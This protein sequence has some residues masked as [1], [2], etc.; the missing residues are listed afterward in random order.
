ML[1]GPFC[2]LLCCSGHITDFNFFW[3][4]GLLWTWFVYEFY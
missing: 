4:F 1:S 2:K 3:S